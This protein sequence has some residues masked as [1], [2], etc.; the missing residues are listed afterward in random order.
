MHDATKGRAMLRC[1]SGAEREGEK[2][3]AEREGEKSGTEESTRR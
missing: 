2:S 1:V 3:G